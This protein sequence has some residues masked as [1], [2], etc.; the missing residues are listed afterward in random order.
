MN[1]TRILL[2]FAVT[3]ILLRGVSVFAGERRAYNA[4]QLKEEPVLDGKIDGD[5]AWEKIMPTEKFSVFITGAVVS[6]Q[7]SF[8]AGYTPEA[9]Y[10]GVECLEPEKTK[11][12]ARFGDMGSLWEE[13]SVEIFFQKPGETDCYQFI[14]NAIG[15]KW[16][17]FW[18]GPALEI[19]TVIPAESWTAKTSLGENYWCAEIKIPFEILKT[20]PVE[21]AAWKFNICRNIYSIDPP[22]HTTWS[23]LL[24]YKPQEPDN[25]GSLVFVDTIPPEVKETPGKEAALNLALPEKEVFLY[26][27]PSSGIYLLK[28]DKE[29]ISFSQSA[30]ASPRISPEGTRIIYH[31]RLDGIDG[32]IG[33]WLMGC[34]GDNAR[35]ICDGQYAEWSPSGGKI[36]FQRG[37]RIMERELETGK[38][39]FFSPDEWINCRFP[40]YLSDKEIIFAAERKGE[41]GIYVG[42]TTGKFIPKLLMKTTEEIVCTPK[43][44]PDGKKIAYLDRGKIHLFNFEA[45]ES[46]RLTTAPGIQSWPVWSGDGESLCYLQAPELLTGPYDLRYLKVNEPQKIGLVDRDIHPSFDWKG[47]SPRIIYWSELK[48]RILDIERKEKEIEVRNSWMALKISLDTN[49]IFLLTQDGNEKTGLLFWD[50][51]NEKINAIGKITSIKEGKE[52]A[53]IEVSFRSGG[54]EAKVSFGLPNY[55]PFLEV[56]AV[57]NISRISLKKSLGMVVLPDRLANDIIFSPSYLK[58]LIALPEA[59]FMVGIPETKKEGLFLLITPSEKQKIQ[60]TVAKDRDVFTGT[61]VYPSMG[62]IFISLLCGESIF[63]QQNLKTAETSDIKLNW[64]QP[65][66]ALWRV[67]LSGETS[68]YSIMQPGEE[69]AK[70]KEAYLPVKTESPEKFD[71]AVVYLYGR[72]WHTPLELIVTPADVLLDVLG[73]EKLQGYLKGIRSYRIAEERVPLE[74][75]LGLFEQNLPYNKIVFAG[76]I[77]GTE[78]SYRLFVHLHNDI[79]NILKGL[80][81]RIQEYRDFIA[82]LKKQAIVSREV[83]EKIESQVNPLPVMPVEKVALSE[84]DIKN[85]KGY[86]S[87]ISVAYTPP[88]GCAKQ[89]DIKEF[90]K[91]IKSSK[92]AVKERRKVLSLYREFVKGLRESAGLKVAESSEPQPAYEELRCKTGEI[93]Q[94]RYYFEDDWRGED[95]MEEVQ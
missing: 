40:S 76:I 68:R 71:R 85:T 10:I 91:F 16:S 78:S 31:S 59:L 75:Y 8:R 72:R 51:K 81:G 34:D 95:P 32:K 39:Q 46:V 53:E 90:V 33:I 62:S 3:L 88:P 54:Q 50:K 79:I 93:L 36:I 41:W 56:R 30:Y 67:A 82:S 29:R 24:V 65:F 48:V 43:A 80:D 89:E 7:T 5:P 87:G 1:K 21:Q 2:A 17:S 38:E 92:E 14:V 64:V 35:R 77:L 9:L 52:Y 69:L 55:S 37:G 61:D 70:L 6:R 94:N 86:L 44:S 45:K 19:K 63:Y 66:Q 4:Y 20:M 74:L 73:A 49:S 12:K 57:E 23:S 26:S 27:K 83:I 15:S 28:A 22:Q 60:L 47:I 11:I 58:P 13:D 42:D 84:Q 25:F 18:N